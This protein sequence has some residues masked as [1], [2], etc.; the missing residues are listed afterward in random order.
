[1]AVNPST[2]AQLLSLS[3]Y[4]GIQSQSSDQQSPFSSTDHDAAQLFGSLLTMMMNGS[5][6]NSSSGRSIPSERSSSASSLSSTNTDQML[7][8]QLADTLPTRN[9]TDS[10]KKSN[11]DYDVI[12]QEMSA[13]YSVPAPLIRSVIDTESGGNPNATSSSGAMGLMQ[14]MPGTAAELGVTNPYDPA[15]NI[16]AGT[17][18]L[19]HLIK[20]YNGDDRLALAAY[21]A[22]SGAVQKYGGVPPFPETQTYVS[23]VLNK[24][25][26]TYG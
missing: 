5:Y 16:E 18:Y 19:S 2:M 4:S 21:N 25:Q 10:L 9:I 23:K 22:G 14:L 24:A 6:S 3:L 7:W 13:K 8:Q 1:M 12:I 15:Q 26:Q 17:R 11:S 20:R